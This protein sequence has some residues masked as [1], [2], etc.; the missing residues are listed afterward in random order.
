[1]SS[2][3]YFE[4]DPAVG[5]RPGEVDLV[6][7]DLQ[8]RLLTDRGVFAANRVDPGTLALLRS[9]PPPPSSGDLLDLGCGYGPIAC[10]L[11]RRAP[12][13][14][15]WAMDVNR[16]ALELVGANARRLGLTNLRPVEPEETPDELRFAGLWTNPPIRIGKPALH[17][18]L[19]RWLPRLLPGAAG[20]MVVHR[21]LGSDSLAAW[22][23]ESGWV[24]DRLGSKRG[25][26]IL[27]VVRAG[28][29][30]P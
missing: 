24:V 22:M 16:R 15:V 17:A 26:R 29:V 8:A 27:R 18:L 19:T 14:T 9:V 5:S 4:A 2:G 21:N 11:A 10:T 7:A 25:Y 12:G 28:D 3:Q 30:G 6:L 13:A 23:A 1:M 20:W